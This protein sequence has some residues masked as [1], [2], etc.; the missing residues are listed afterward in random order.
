MPNHIPAV[1]V[2]SGGRTG[3]AYSRMAETVFMA[4]TL[5]AATIL[6]NLNYFTGRDT[7]ADIDKFELARSLHP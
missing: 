4:N 3:D 7:G 2:N 6:A 5:L 1:H